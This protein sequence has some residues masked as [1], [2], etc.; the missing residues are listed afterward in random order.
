MNNIN[1]LGDFSL[2]QKEITYAYENVPF[3]G[4]LLNRHSLHPDNIRRP[5][6]MDKLPPTSKRHYRRNF[7]YGVLAKGISIGDPFL[8]QVP[9][10]G[11]E[12]ERLLTVEYSALY[13]LRL[14]ECLEVAPGFKKPFKAR[15]RRHVWYAPPNCSDVECANPNS[16]TEDRLLA[17]GRLILSV[18]HDLLTTSE[19]LIEQTIQEIDTYQ[20]N[21]YYADPTHLAFLIREMKKRNHRPHVAPIALTFTQCTHVSRRQIEEFFPDDTPC[22]QAVSM[23][24]FGWVV[25]ECP[26]GH[27]HL[28]NKSFFVEFIRDG[29]E[30][31]PGELCELV[32]T[33]L[34]RGATP[35]I[36]YKTGD[37]YSYSEE[38]CECGSPYP[39]VHMEG[40]V[41]SMLF[42]NGS[43][44]LTSRQ[45][46]E[47][48]VPNSAGIDLYKLEQLDERIFKLSLI[49]NEGFEYASAERITCDL[50][51]VLGRDIRIDIDI[52]DYIASERSGKFASCTSRVGAKLAQKGFS[53]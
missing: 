45:L 24:E 3:F 35:H 40:R 37:I 7:P 8:D 51:E 36:R 21:L 6:D 27:L 42:R 9:S 41:K 29:R 50:N 14:L 5:S 12:S 48:I 22:L 13:S 38:S 26:K 43:I 10:S 47:L 2:V 17:D 16:T 18:Y 23:S 49:V 25:V 11:T 30:A 32:L 20:P 33:G 15:G 19:R 44:A 28:N 46:D 34:G 31:T 53:L 1:F 4:E 52:V 39:V